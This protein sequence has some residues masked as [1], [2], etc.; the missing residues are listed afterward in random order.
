MGDFLFRRLLPAA[1][2]VPI[3]IGWLRFE[4]ERAGLYGAGFGVV[5]TTTANVIIIT[6]LILWSARWLNRME[7]ERK[8]AEEALRESQGQFQDLFE[9]AVDSLIYT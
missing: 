1:I 7:A 4:G 2:V 3:V 5:L 6:A 8:Q 9:Q